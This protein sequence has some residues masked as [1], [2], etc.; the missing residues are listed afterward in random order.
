MRAVRQPAQNEAFEPLIQVECIHCG[1]CILVP[2]TVQGKAGV[3][4]SCGQ[5]LLVPGAPAGNAARHLEL[6]FRRGD[7]IAERYVVDERIGSGGMGVVYRAQDTLVEETVA[8]KFMKPQLLRTRKGQQLFIR[9]AQI[10]RRLRH[11]NIVAVHDV[12][13]TGDGILYLSMEFAEGQP[14]R[15]FLRKH[16][17]ERRHVNVRLSVTFIRQILAA[18]EFA[19]RTVVHRDM[20]PENVMLLSGER[21]KVLDFGLAKAI[22]EE[23]L[24]AQIEQEKEAAKKKRVIGTLAYASPEQRRRQQVDHRADIYAVGLLMQELFTLRTPLDESVTVTQ[25]RD[26]VSPSLLAVLDKALSEEKEQRWQSAGEFRRALERAYDESYRKTMAVVA[27]QDRDTAPGAP[28]ADEL[29]SGAAGMVLLE[30]GNFLMGNDNVHEEAPEEEV[31]VFPFWMDVYPVTVEQYRRFMAAMAESGET[32]QEPRFWRDPQYNGA[33]QPVVGVSWAEANAYARWAGKVLPSEIQ[34]EYA[35]RG[36][37]NRRYPW[38]HLQPDTTLCN[39]RDYLGMPSIVTMHD[40]GRTPDGLYDLAGNVYEWTEDPFV[41]YA[42]FRRDQKGANKAP[43]R[44]IRGGCFSSKAESLPCTA[45][46]GVFPEARENDLGFRCV[47]PA[48]KP[49][50]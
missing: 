42:K 47:I 7:R 18:L 46:K 30:G 41:P 50:A 49:Q 1:T 22:H 36:K 31:H 19:H 14:L 39:F 37:D 45:R 43:R 12:S 10:A 32:V 21:V 38:G 16:R 20:K 48:G 33:D 9:E 4:F 11:E 24:S 8:L 34:W 2:P 27:E 13:W 6:D 5:A 3:C 17:T 35:A 28:T 44:A 26:D 40:D 23:F 15:A 29:N 25:V